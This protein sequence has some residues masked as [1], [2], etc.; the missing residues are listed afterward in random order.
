MRKAYRRTQVPSHKPDPGYLEELQKIITSTQEYGGGEN[1]SIK[2]VF[3]GLFANFPLKV[4]PKNFELWVASSRFSK[5]VLY[6]AFY[7]NYVWQL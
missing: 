5:V 4:K 3:Y 2:L 7:S 1:K 6:K